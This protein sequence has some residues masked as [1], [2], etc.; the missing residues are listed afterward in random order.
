MLLWILIAAIIVNLIL[1][2]LP[3][4][5]VGALIWLSIF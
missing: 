4:I 5:I 1:D 3:I 2:L